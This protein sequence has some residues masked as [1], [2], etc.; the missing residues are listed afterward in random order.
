MD[1]R[2]FA[3]LGKKIFFAKLYRG[4]RPKKKKKTGDSK[5][6]KEACQNGANRTR[7]AVEPEHAP[8]KKKARRRPIVF[9]NA[10]TQTLDSE[11]NGA[12]QSGALREFTC[13][14]SRSFSL[15]VRSAVRISPQG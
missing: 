9:D 15:F 8:K 4:R 7:A 2:L 3:V 5:A 1:H 13:S 11:R 14:A 12:G 6:V 10:V